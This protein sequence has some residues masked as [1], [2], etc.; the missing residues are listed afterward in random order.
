MNY[1]Y[2]KVYLPDGTLDELTIK[3]SDGVMFNKNGTTNYKHEFDKWIAD[4]NTVIDN[5]PEETP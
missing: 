1:S 2:F 4:G 5:K 3:R